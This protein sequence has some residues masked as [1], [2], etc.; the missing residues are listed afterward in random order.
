[1]AVPDAPPPPA[2]PPRHQDPYTVD[3]GELICH[4]CGEHVTLRSNAGI[5]EET[6]RLSEYLLPRPVPSCPDP[7]C[8]NH[9]RSVHDKSAASFYRENGK[10]RG[11]SKRFLCKACGTTFSVARATT[12]QRRSKV[13]PLLFKLLLA[14]VSLSKVASILEISPPTLYDKLDL[15]RD[16]CLR[17][18]GDRERTLIGR[19]FDEVRLAT[20]R[21]A[22]LC[23]WVRP[24]LYKKSIIV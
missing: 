14:R 24:A 21:Q 16:Q 20:D 15:L 4:A 3:G 11:G 7:T 23:N 8:T 18:Q 5:V 9:S 19:R 10:T 13:N 1:V 22:Y 17:F 6:A 2:P 12:G